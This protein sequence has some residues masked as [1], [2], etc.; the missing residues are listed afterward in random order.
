MPTPILLA[1]HG[2]AVAELLPALA[3]RHG[4]ITGATGTGKT[5]TLQK[6]A[7][8]FSQIGVPVFM[9]DVK[10][11]LTGISQTG[12]PSEKLLG[13]LKD[14]AWT[15]RPPLPAPR[16]CGTCLASRATRCAPRCR[17]GPLLLGAH[18]GAERD[19]GRRAAD[20]VQDRRRQRPAGAGPEGPARHAAVRG[21][22]RQ[23]FTTQYGNVSAASVGAIQR[24]PCRSRPRAATSSLASPCSTSPT[25]CRPRAGGRHQ[26]P[27][28]R[29]ADERA[30]ALRHL[31]A[32]DA[33]RAVRDP[34]R[35]GRPGASPSWCSSSTRLTCLQGRA[36]R[37]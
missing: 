25:S 13:I 29:Q 7:E 3:N 22:Q 35:G 6:L 18:A 4:L 26:H 24:G 20:G 2:D 31:P 8:G 17:H 10:G 1:R 19:A 33:V 30:A 28:R 11:D 15:R 9:A 14:A 32:V 5:I 23:Q 16:R 12:K 36:P 27:G 37:R 34:A 21:R